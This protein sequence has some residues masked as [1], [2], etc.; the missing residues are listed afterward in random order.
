MT[1]RDL[2]TKIKKVIAEASPL[3]TAM[4]LLLL[5]GSVAA[6]LWFVEKRKEHESFKYQRERTVYWYV[7]PIFKSMC[8]KSAASASNDISEYHEFCEWEPEFGARVLSSVSANQVT[9]YRYIKGSELVI[10]DDIERIEG[11]ARHNATLR[12]ANM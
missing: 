1:N 7:F 4:I 8:L 11:V 12:F 9:F 2:F 3:M 6:S 5:V 10:P